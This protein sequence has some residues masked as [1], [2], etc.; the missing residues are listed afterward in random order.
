MV[1]S[2]PGDPELLTL[3]AH[4]MLL[5]PSALVV[6]DRLVPP[7]I[8]SLVRGELRVANKAPGCAERAQREIYAWCREGLEEGRRVVRLKIGDPF[9]F[10]RGGE[11]VLEFR[12][13]GVEPTV[14]PGVSASLS[15][16]LLAGIP[17]THRGV[18]NQVVVC[19]GY[20]REGTSPDLIRYHPEQTVVFLMAVGKLPT[21]SA[22]LISSAAY[23]PSTRVAIVESAGTPQQ[24]VVLGPLDRIASIAEENGV[25][26]PATIVVGDVVD[27]LIGEGGK[28]E[29]VA[30]G[31]SVTGA[32]AAAAGMT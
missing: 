27:V 7:A 13:M 2:G 15:A 19:T 5:D 6:A 10:G 24:R 28:V 8:L 14:V 25:R 1:G 4:R 18:A 32:I 11:E 22:S 23:P 21:L 30:E 3:A 9:V 26:A 17:V 12:G 16:P 29:G 31:G 20:G